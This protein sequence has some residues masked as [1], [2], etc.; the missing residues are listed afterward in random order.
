[1]FD[2]KSI[3]KDIE[4]YLEKPLKFKYGLPQCEINGFRDDF[5]VTLKVESSDEFNNIINFPQSIYYIN[6][7]DI[8]FDFSFIG[9]PLILNE[10][11]N[12][13]IKLKKEYSREFTK[14]LALNKIIPKVISHIEKKPEYKVKNNTAFQKKS[15][16]NTI[17]INFSV[18]FKDGSVIYEM[19]PKKII[20]NIKNHFEAIGLNDQNVHIWHNSIE[21]F[22][23]YENGI[24][25]DNYYWIWLEAFN[26]IEKTSFNL[27]SIKDIELLEMY[28]L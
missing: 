22:L 9:D 10:I 8:K 27:E 20:Y 21:P 12:N 7:N 13:D 25:M 15:I 17:K 24:L 11:F 16:Y 14:I 19:I 18:H 28:L 23:R 3:L 26:K 6:K 4:N 1:M 5:T 2:I